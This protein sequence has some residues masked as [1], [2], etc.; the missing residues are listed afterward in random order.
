MSDMYVF[1]NEATKTSAEDYVGKILITD[2][3]VMPPYV[4]PIPL[5]T[6]SAGILVQ[7]ASYKC[8][9]IHRITVTFI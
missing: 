3:A 2:V 8:F 4:F 5:W 9:E 7:L 6:F 1:V